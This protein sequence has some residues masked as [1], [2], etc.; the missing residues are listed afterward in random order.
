MYPGTG[1]MEALGVTRVNAHDPGSVELQPGVSVLDTARSPRGTP[2]TNRDLDYNDRVTVNGMEMTI[3]TALSIGALDRVPGG[4]FKER[5]GSGSPPAAPAAPAPA[6]VQQPAQPSG[7]ALDPTVVEAHAK[8]QLSLPGSTLDK[9]VAQVIA[10]G[11]DSVNLSIA[12]QMGANRAEVQANLRAV[13]SGLHQQASAAMG[14]MGV[15][16][17]HF[18][19]WARAK[20]GDDLKR[21]MH[22]HYLTGDTSAYVE[23]ADRYTRTVTPSVQT[24]EAAGLKTW[25][26]RSRGE[27]LVNINGTTMSVKAAAQLR[28]V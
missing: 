13:V 7:P 22:Q 26:D 21:A 28:L 18:T 1:E 14:E 25:F 9:V 2:I 20:A 8:L 5:G 27:Q 11:V 12:D 3:G 17:T 10:G 4:G 23:L 15:D 19:Q 6:T 16:M 24:L